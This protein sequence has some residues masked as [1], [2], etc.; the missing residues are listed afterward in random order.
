M[1][2]MSLNICSKLN[3]KPDALI[4][5]YDVVGVSPAYMG[6]G[7]VSAVENL[8]KK[9]SLDIEDIDIF[10]INESFAS[11]SVA[12]RKELG[13]PLQKINVNGGA[14]AL[15]HPVGAVEQEYWRH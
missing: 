6:M 4:K 14:I 10:E 11:Q 5:A 1:G 8:L 15:G 7:P 12:V 3:L 2:V 13:I 9:C